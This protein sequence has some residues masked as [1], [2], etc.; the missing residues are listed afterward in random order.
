VS[1]FPIPET[2]LDRHR[3]ITPAACAYAAGFFDGEGTVF[4]AIDRGR[5]EARGPI[6]NMR[7]MA[8]Q[9]DRTPLIW[10]QER[11]D[12]TLH[13]RPALGT[14]MEAATWNCFSKKAAKFLR[15]VRPYLIVKAREADIALEFQAMLFNPGW[16][17]HSAEYRE[18]QDRLRNTLM[19]LKH[20]RGAIA[21]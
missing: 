3:L 17:G 4:I 6:Y 12:G 9:V 19:A 15:D 18:R 20:D 5:K 21:A 7:V 13:T 14:R 8:S 10:F 1:R 2:V 16:G 11:W